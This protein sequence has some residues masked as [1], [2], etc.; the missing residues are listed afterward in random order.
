M[1]VVVETAVDR[2]AGG[3][4]SHVP[5]AAEKHLLP[6]LEVDLRIVLDVGKLH[7]DDR[8]A[9]HLPGP[10]TGP[11]QAMASLRGKRHHQLDL[12]AA[13][14]NEQRQQVAGLLFGKE[15]GQTFRSWGVH[16]IDLLDEVS[17]LQPGDGGRRAGSDLQD[18]D[19][20][21]FLPLAPLHAQERPSPRHP[22]GLAGGDQHGPDLDRLVLS[23]QGEFHRLARARPLHLG[24]EGRRCGH[25]LPAQ[26]GDDVA[27]FD[28]GPGRG[29]IGLDV[30]DDQSVAISALDGHAQVARLADCSRRGVRSWAVTS[31]ATVRYSARAVEAETFS[32]GRGAG[33]GSSAAS[34]EQEPAST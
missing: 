19:T 2:L 10:D 25:R 18:A 31:W 16:T 13:A 30:L 11:H 32:A 14:A 17:L 12:L 7:A 23:Q 28:S 34:R 26:P 20:F 4:G 15:L 33:L 3:A 24:A 29:R 8:E 22:Q 21:A 6:L 1:E 27:F 9:K 5:A